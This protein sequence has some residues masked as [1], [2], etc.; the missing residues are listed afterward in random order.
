M[1]SVVWAGWHLPLFGITDT[2]RSMPAA[3]F[4]GFYLSLLVASLALAWLYL[5]SNGS[6]ARPGRV[7][8]RLGRT[9]PPTH[10]PR[11]H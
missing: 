10:P 4:L 6:F 11:P 9:S 3:S 5:R 1:V 8:R 7:P 2:Y